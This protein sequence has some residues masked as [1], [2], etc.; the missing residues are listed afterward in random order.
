[1]RTVLAFVTLVLMLWAA[2][3]AASPRT[4]SYRRYKLHELVC[5]ADVVVSGTITNV[6][7]NPSPERGRTSGGERDTFTFEVEETIAGREPGKSI[8]VACFR[9]WTCAARWAPY[10]KGQRAVLFLD[11]PRA[12]SSAYTV[13][14]AGNEGE[15]PREDESVVALGYGI[16]GLVEPGRPRGEYDVR[17][18]RVPLTEFAAAVRGFREHLS[19]KLDARTG[20][21]V[22]VHPSG[23]LEKTKL[24]AASS[25]T[26]RQLFADVRSSGAWTGPVEPVPEMR[27][28]ADVRTCTS[29]TRF[30]G[31]P[32]CVVGDV[33]GDGQADIASGFPYDSAVINQHG[34][35]EIAF[36]AADGSVGRKRRLDQSVDSFPAR[37]NEFAQLGRGVAPAGDLDGDG[38]P[39]LVVS[40]PGNG[41][42][43]KGRG[44]V[45]V[46]ALRRDGSVRRAIA[47][48]GDEKLRALGVV[49]GSGLGSSI[50]TLGD[51]D[52]D[53]FV[54]LA[55]GQDPEFDMSQESG[56]AV[57]VVSLGR[58]GVVRWA[59]R[60][61]DRTDGFAERYSWFG[62]AL[63][64]LGD[65]D[66]DGVPDVAISDSYCSD[67][68]EQRGSVWIVCLQRNGAVKRKSKISDW[69]GNFDGHL[70][71]E[72]GFGRALHALGDIDADGV[73][74]LA[75]STW[76]RL[77]ILGL[78]RAGSVR[79]AR[80]LPMSRASRSDS[81]REFSSLVGLPAAPGSRERR[82]VLDGTEGGEQRLWF[83]RF[84]PKGEPQGW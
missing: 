22:E 46:L 14:G 55:I 71:D 21:P 23:D 79:S 17:G 18:S 32:A 1:M 62:D 37:M 84:D 11:A 80:V 76:N 82:F 16:R 2:L 8:T 3:D 9:N 60:L 69:S 74:D 20:L 48:D 26:A 56:R 34:A 43:W 7:S 72:D 40:A 42:S 81:G 77:W 30:F 66:G 70:R 39:D 4:L 49:I 15:M 52:G 29:E 27:L 35:V 50:A 73:P 68:G 38:V 75:A 13:L 54:E 10:E 25:P 64:G 33:D 51:L 47:I 61:H 28:P 53:G 36:L 65:V 31:S 41:G 63:A 24:Y 19:W 45:W 6:S 67:G 5:R 78:D 44:S 58:E 83:V 59:T 57:Y 12:D